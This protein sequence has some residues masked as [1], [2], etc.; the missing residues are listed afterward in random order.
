MG[1]DFMDMQ[2]LGGVGI[3]GLIAWFVMLYYMF[4]DVL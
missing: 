2:V 1:G 4:R 3:F